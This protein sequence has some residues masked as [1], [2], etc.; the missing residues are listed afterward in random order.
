MVTLCVDWSE[1]V[2]VAVSCAVV[3][4]ARVGFV[5]IR[6]SEISMTAETSEAASADAGA[7]DDAPI[8]PLASFPPADGLF[9]QD[10]DPDPENETQQ[11]AA[12]N[13]H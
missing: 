12:Q 5:G 2:P 1:N 9:P 7:S 6:A 3:P 13:R 10:P 4:V 11:A 8:S